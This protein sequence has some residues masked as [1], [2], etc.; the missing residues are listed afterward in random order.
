M[1]PELLNLALSRFAAPEWIIHITD[2]G[3]R[4]LASTSENRIGTTSSTAQYVLKV[5][6]PASI[7]SAADMASGADSA[8]A[9]HYGTPVFAGEE[10][11]GTVIV[12]GP[13]S[14]VAVH[15]GTIRLFLETF[16]EYEN[17][18]QHSDEESGE[19]VQ[20]AR[21]LLSTQ[22]DAERATSLMYRREMDPN[23]LRSVIC[24]RLE[25]HQTRYFNINLSLGYQSSIECIK[26]EAVQKLRAGRYLNSQD[27]VHVFNRNTLVVIKSFIPVDDLSRIYLS[28]DAICRDMAEALAPFT[29]FSFHIAY[30]NLYAGINSLKKSLD[31]AFETI[32]IGRVAQ[33]EERVHI[34]EDLL[35]EKIGQNLDSQIVNKLL[36][37]GIK[38]LLRKDGSAPHKLI[39]CCEAYVDCCMNF[40]ATAERTGLHRNTISA[41]LE[42]L[43]QLTGLD[44]AA[45]FHDAFLVKML[46][47]CLRE[48]SLQA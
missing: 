12:H 11:V 10:L 17:L 13:T 16:L 26:Q 14:S 30:G 25:Y 31:Q 6:R 39:D 32:D 41:R 22:V 21:L 20:L 40:S 38:K 45:S 19:L 4:I 2:S 47:V 1:N 15:G 8:P 29:A 35:F 9:M 24:I 33:P 48:T 46:A 27:I 36:Q 18:R 42:K 34:L 44:P 28:L 23:L 37:P 7:E 43:K 5:Q 3:A